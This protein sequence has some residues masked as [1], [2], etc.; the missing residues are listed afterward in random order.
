MTGYKSLTEADAIEYCRRVGLFAQDETL[1]SGEIGDGNLNLVFRIVSPLRS[2]SV[3]VKQALPYARCV[4][5]AMPLTIDRARIE[6]EALR[7]QGQFC[8]EMV[9]EVHHFNTELA[10]TV[11]EDLKDYEVMRGALIRSSTYPKFASDIATFMARTLFG[12]SDFA[13]APDEK[14]ALVSK[15][16][17][18][19]LCKI[20]EDLVFTEP[21]YDAPNNHYDEAI[22][23]TVIDL[24]RDN[25]LL[26]E[27][28]T[29][30]YKFMTE[31][32]ALVHGDL[33]TG[34]V[35]VRSDGIKVFD[36][37]FA[38]FGPMGFDIGAIIANLLLSYAAHFYQSDSNLFN[39]WVLGTVK[40]IWTK[41]EQAFRHLYDQSGSRAFTRFPQLLNS[42][43]AQLLQ[44]SIGF[45]GCKMIRRV[46]GLA[47]VAD[48]DSLADS[49]VKNK[50]EILALRM[51]QQLVKMRQQVRTIDDVIAIVNNQG[52]F[53]G[54]R[55]STGGV[56]R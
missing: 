39:H 10:I 44:D 43:L 19:E 30:K 11:M 14:K 34:S 53:H 25:E 47:H 22:E 4:G 1:E 46:I 29:L 37:E 8:K 28:M 15:F 3:I 48:L 12:T 33:H 6:A 2:H 5:E 18:P 32:Q 40:E 38:Y 42:F 45:A 27:V 55:I 49:T 13:L 36:P 52:D 56:E 21:Y 17:N 20:T 24:R 23:D 16:I 9:P 35:M 7:I 26:Q 31:A 54:T 51:G 41:F 50:A